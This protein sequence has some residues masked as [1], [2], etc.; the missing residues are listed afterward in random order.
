MDYATSA[1][2]AQFDRR[3]ATASFIVNLFTFHSKHGTSPDLTAP[4]V[5]M[6]L[7][8]PPEH[9]DRDMVDECHRIARAVATTVEN[10]YV[11]EWSAEDY[12]KDV[13]GGVLV[14]PEHEATLMRKYPPLID[15]HKVLNSMEEHLPIIDDRPAV[16][17][18]RDG[19]VLVWSLPGILPEKRQMEILKATRC[20]EA[21]LST[22]PVPP[23]EPIMKHWRSGKPFFS[24]SGD[25]LSGTT[26]LYVAGFAQGHTGPKHPLIPS[27]DAK[28]QRAKDWMAE[29]ETSGGVLDGILAIT[30]PGL[31]DAARAVAETIWQ[32]RGT[33]HSLMEL[34]PTCFSSIQ[35]I[36]NRGTP[37]HRDNSALPGWLDL[38]LSLRTYGENGVL[39][40]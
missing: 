16:I 35:V 15:V 9:I 18:D 1:L 26:L 38:L 3:A 8:A 30:H 25:W 5:F 19:N 21:Q 28:S 27:A 4:R 34:W 17:T 37:R 24:K 40:L 6:D 13:G 39:E 12:A 2:P 32:K 36:A 23:D 10:K 22:K 29:F 7:P 11:L 14:K 31:Y 33:S 20:I